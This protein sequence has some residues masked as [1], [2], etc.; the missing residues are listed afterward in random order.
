M[1]EYMT[2]LGIVL[3]LIS[4]SNM[5]IP[6]GSIKKYTSLAMGFMLICAALS[7]IPSEESLFSAETFN[8]DTEEVARNEAYYRAQVLKRHR[9]NLEK[10]IEERLKHGGSANVEIS[11]QGEV[12]SV[13]LLVNGDESGAVAYIIE[14]FGITRERIK[15]KYDKN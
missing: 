1:R 4:F 10:N 11:P 14:N 5:L 15:M 9:D 8:L 12:I 7:Y 2:S 3:M 13:T 6:E